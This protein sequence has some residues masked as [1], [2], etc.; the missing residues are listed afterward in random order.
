MTFSTTNSDYVPVLSGFC[1][2]AKHEPVR[3]PE[4]AATGPGLPESNTSLTLKVTV[5]QATKSS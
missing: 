2:H 5:A 4:V 1:F 3:R